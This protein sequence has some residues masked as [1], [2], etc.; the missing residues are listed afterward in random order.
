MTRKIFGRIF[1]ARTA[2]LYWA[3]DVLVYFVSVTPWK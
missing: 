1:T 2:R 3:N